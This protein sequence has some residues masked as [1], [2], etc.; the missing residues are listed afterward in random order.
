MNDGKEDES[1]KPVVFAV[2]PYSKGISEVCKGSSRNI[3]SVSTQRQANPCANALH[4]QMINAVL[5]TSMNVHVISVA[6]REI[7]W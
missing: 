1:T 3:K 4:G 7:T 2:L 5:C 6:N